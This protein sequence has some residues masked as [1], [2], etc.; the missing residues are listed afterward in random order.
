[1]FNV[2][3]F[4]DTPPGVGPYLNN[5]FTETPP[6]EVGSWAI[7]EVYPDMKIQ[8]PVRI[9]NMPGTDDLL[10]LSKR[11]LLYQVSI[12]DQTQRLI[13]DIQDRTFKKGEAGSVGLALH[14]KFGNPAFPDKQLL[15]L[16]YRYKPD[17]DEWDEK[18]YNRLSSFEWD[19]N[20]LSFDASSEYIFIQQ[21]DECSWHN[22]GGMFF[23][24]DGFLY[25]SVGDEGFDDQQ[26]RSTQRLDG[27]LTSGI[28]RI[29]IDNDPNKSHPIM[30][31]PKSLATPRSG[32]PGTFSQGYSIPNDN[33]WLSED[34]SIL[35]EF[36]ALGI[37]SPYSTYFDE[38]EEEIWVLDVGSS[39]REEVNKVYRGDNLQW[40]Y[41]EGTIESEI[42][43]RPQ[44]IIG[45]ERAPIYEYDR[46]IG[47]SVIAG[48]I[49]REGKFPSLFGKFLMGDFVTNKLM[50]LSV[51]AGSEPK[52]NVLIPKITSFGFELPET[53]GITGVNLMEDGNVYITVMGVKDQESFG[54]LFKLKQNV[55]LPDPPEKLSD[56][57]VFKNLNTLTP[58]EGII[59]YSVNSPLWS[60]GAL[61]KRWIAIPEGEQIDFRSNTNWIFPEGTVFIKHFELPLSDDGDSKRLET[62]FFVIGK[63]NQNYGVTYKW[64]EDDSEAYLLSIGEKE[65]FIVE[66]NGITFTQTWDYPSRD[67]CMSCHNPTAD[68]V[69]GF[70]THQ[71]NKDHT[72]I[73]MGMTMNQIE[74]L[75]Q[76]DMFFQE[77]PNVNELH[78]S[79]ALEDES[80]DLELRILSY[81]DSNCSS[82]HRLGGVPKVSMD[83]RSTVPLPLQ[84]TVS[85]ET[86]S[87]AS[88]QNN[89]II[90]PGDHANSELWI[91]DASLK[92][93]KMPP[94]ARNLIDEKYIEL[95]AEWIDGLSE[96]D[97]KIEDILL[98]PNPSDGQFI[99]R[100]NEEWEG[101]KD[102]KVIS[103]SGQLVHSESTEEQVVYLELL[104]LVS[105]V[106]VLTAES[107]AGKLLKQIVVQ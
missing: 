11:G 87:L 36:Y 72:Y 84:N 96:E 50:S 68:H 22:G 69:L 43:E 48:G 42:H 41:M 78:K 60:D 58:T 21:Y 14:P 61:K 26:P 88:I 106:Y 19:K 95:L 83:L 75:S 85:F 5:L 52:M 10:V 49:Y 9:K 82:C 91:R 77:I 90:K 67:Q 29:D 4:Y 56:L 81:L 94:L 51:V 24:P 44:S 6:G 62:R 17:P 23:G 7:D 74:F 8:S 73:N 1:M 27:G 30:R 18:G 93:N 47:Q 86:N 102:I 107:S 57:N 66:R 105:G 54:R 45:N 31:H 65:D 99:L 76:E 25:L 92:E 53:P 32:W 20:T 2:G 79:Y 89:L 64:N 28:L 3:S 104:N 38:M 63:D 37:R 98:Y 101:I 100:F 103:S 15:Y 12:E 80:V 33:P 97:G 46:S 34:G 35:E 16:F 39:I 13:L 70:N 71:L 55:I 59:P 40:P